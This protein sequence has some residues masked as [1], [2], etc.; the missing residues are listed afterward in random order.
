LLAQFDQ[1][2][3]RSIDRYIEPFVGG[4]AVFFHLQA[5]LPRDACIPSRQ[6]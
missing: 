4:G 1:L 2:F 6:Q 5:P 3:P